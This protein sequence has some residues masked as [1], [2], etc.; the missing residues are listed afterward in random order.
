MNLSAFNDPISNRIIHVAQEVRPQAQIP[1]Y[2]YTL[3]GA[4]AGLS[5][6]PLGPLI[7]AAIDTILGG[8]KITTTLRLKNF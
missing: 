6:L 4:L 8:V 3:I 7:G 5:F 2:A 1:V